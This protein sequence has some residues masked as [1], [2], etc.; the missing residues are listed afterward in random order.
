MAAVKRITI[1][2]TVLLAVLF[3]FL[4]A[5]DKETVTERDQT[6]PAVA[7]L[8]DSPAKEE[9]LRI[10]ESESAAVMARAELNRQEDVTGGVQVE[11]L[12][13]TETALSFAIIKNSPELSVYG[14]ACYYN[15]D[16]DTGGHITLEDVLGADYRNT[17][18]TA[19]NA[20]LE[21]DAELRERLYGVDIAPLINR[22]R[23]FYVT[24]TGVTAVF[25]VGEI[26][27][28]DYGIVEITVKYAAGQ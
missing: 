3:I 13:E 26:A 14:R 18:M 22:D 6:V 11:I 4:F 10:L 12:G 9:L 2:S 28:E 21:E 25:D 5:P 1:V 24:D 20:R 16:P 7:E 15:L 8:A 23:M 19:V 27:D 17:V